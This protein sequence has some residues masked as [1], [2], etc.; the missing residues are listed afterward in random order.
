MKICGHLLPNY[1]STSSDAAAAEFRAMESLL[2]Q[3]LLRQTV[4]GSFRSKREFDRMAAS[5]PSA[6]DWL[7]Q[8]DS[9]DME[10]DTR[11]YSRDVG[12]QRRPS[13]SQLLD[14][15]TGNASTGPSLSSGHMRAR[16]LAE[17][18]ANGIENESE[19]FPTLLLFEESIC[20]S[21]IHWIG[22]HSTQ[23]ERT[24]IRS[25]LTALQLFES[26]WQAQLYRTRWHRLLAALDRRLLPKAMELKEVSLWKTPRSKKTLQGVRRRRRSSPVT[27]TSLV[28]PS[29]LVHQKLLSRLARSLPCELVALLP[30]N[31][32]KAGLQC[33]A[34]AVTYDSSRTVAPSDYADLTLS[35][36][37][38]ARGC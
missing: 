8:Q 6:L 35:H 32:E 26:E 14:A 31:I 2:T 4:N 20:G 21:L 7:V 33:T 5:Y 34:Q 12:R 28:E 1:L 15:R 30:A 13:L 37:S 36:D 27:S 29:V 9:S 24:L 38:P 23:A 10:A 16:S 17:H 11:E 18:I 3:R 25:V 19:S 22:E